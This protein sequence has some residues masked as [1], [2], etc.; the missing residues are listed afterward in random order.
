MG[1]QGHNLGQ[2]A[3][4]SPLVYVP[5][6]AVQGR[7]ILALG[8]QLRYWQASNV[9]SCVGLVCGDV[10]L[11]DK[12]VLFGPEWAELL[13]QCQMEASGTACSWFAPPSNFHEGWQHGYDQLPE[14]VRTP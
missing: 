7:L 10:L 1:N 11:D 4:H 6:I 3:E 5:E 13:A 9:V 12:R 8:K 14:T 2:V